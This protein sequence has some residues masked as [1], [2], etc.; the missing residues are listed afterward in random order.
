MR[1]RLPNIWAIARLSKVRGDNIR[2][3]I[4]Y[5]KRR[6]QRKKWKSRLPPNCRMSLNQ[7]PGD[8]LIFLPGVGEIFRTARELESIANKH[9]LKLLQ[10]YGDL[11]LEKQDEVLSLR[12]HSVRSILATNVAESSLTIDGVTGVIDSGLARSMQF[13]HELG[14]DRSRTRPDLSGECRSANRKGRADS[15]PVIVLTTLG[16]GPTSASS[17]T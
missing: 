10:L 9:N 3:K 14:L 17:R 7:T 11:P 12:A 2:S 1:N 4:K 16:T 15:H 8:I 5:L 13:N 6:D